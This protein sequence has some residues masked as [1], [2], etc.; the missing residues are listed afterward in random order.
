[1]FQ[2]APPVRDR[3]S[4]WRA[5]G[6]H[7]LGRSRESRAII[8]A[9][10]PTAGG[11]HEQRSRRHEARGDRHSRVRR[12]SRQELLREPRLR[13][14]ADVAVGDDFRLVQMTPP[15]S[16]VLGPVRRESLHGPP[17]SPESLFLVVSDIEARATSWRRSVSTSAR[18]STKARWAIASTPRPETRTVARSQQL[19]LVRRVQRSGRQRGCSRRSRRGCPDGSTPTRRR[20][21][22]LP[23]CHGRCSAR[24]PRTESTRREQVSRTRTGRTG[25]PN[26]WFGNR[27]A[28]RCRTE[29][30]ATRPPPAVARRGHDG[31]RRLVRCVRRLRA[32]A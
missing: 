10:Q 3:S 15:G 29:P 1:M 22:P 12:R 4:P 26:T 23:I 5:A 21:P 30:S 18:F 13:L 24:R 31:R 19:R 11:R 9:V 8:E 27:Q 17:G 25:M 28:R 32:D 7:Y 2:R 16:R 6:N 20:S 14:D